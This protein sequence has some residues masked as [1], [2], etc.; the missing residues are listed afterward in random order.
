MT[1]VYTPRR[2]AS[3][4]TEPAY[5]SILDF[6][7]PEPG[8]DQLLWFK[9]PSQ[10]SLVTATLG[11]ECTWLGDAFCVISSQRQ[12]CLKDGDVPNNTF[13]ITGDCVRVSAP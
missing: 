12:A 6:Q 9:L 4:G 8:D 10:W 2:E 3:G 7:L 5:T 1:A 13:T 11:N